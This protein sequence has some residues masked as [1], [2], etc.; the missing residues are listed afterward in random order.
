MVRF[1]LTAYKRKGCHCSFADGLLMVAVFKTEHSAAV[2]A[3][4]SCPCARISYSL[5]WK[6]SRIIVL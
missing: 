2:N 6:T 1:A 4:Y 5:T 3:M